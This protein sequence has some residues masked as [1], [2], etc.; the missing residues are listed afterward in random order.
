MDSLSIWI[1][2]ATDGASRAPSRETE[3]RW[4]LEAALPFGGRRKKLARCS[5]ESLCNVLQYELSNLSI[6]EISGEVQSFKC[7]DENKFKLFLRQL[8]LT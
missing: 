8:M 2:R 4:S 1:L 5:K 3:H 7:S 6:T